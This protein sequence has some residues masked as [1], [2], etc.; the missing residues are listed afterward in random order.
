M[1]IDIERLYGQTFYDIQRI[2]S[3]DGQRWKDN[4]NTLFDILEEVYD[5]VLGQ[6]DTSHM[7][8]FV[9][10]RKVDVNGNIDKEPNR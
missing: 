9:E 10:F 3:Q 2:I 4:R 1:E 5:E 7:G 6:Y 8:T